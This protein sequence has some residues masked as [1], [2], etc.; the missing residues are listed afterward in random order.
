MR[1]TF[2]LADQF[3]DQ[4]VAE[5]PTLA[6][7]L[8]IAGHDHRWDDLS[9][10]GADRFADLIRGHS[11]ALAPY[12][13]HPDRW[14]RHAARV[15]S[16][17]IGELL[18]AYDRQEHLRALRHLAGDFQDIRDVFDQ[19]GT[20]TREDWDNVIARLTTVSEPLQGHRE[21]LE[22]G[23]H[24]GLAAARRQV[25]AVLEQA[26][27]LAGPEG[28]W[29]GLVEKAQ[30]STDP[31][32]ATRLHEAVTQAQAAVATFGDYLERDYL[33]AAPEA[34][35]VGAERYV[36]EADRYLGLRI[37]PLDTYEWGWEEVERINQA[38]IGT[39]RHI[40]PDA[41][42]EE[43]IERLETD[44]SYA[45]P[46]QEAFIEFMQQ[47]QDQAL[48][49]LDGSHFD[50]PIAIRK[51]TVNLVPPGS[52][53]GAYYLPPSEDFTRPGG[54]WYSFGARPQIPLWGEVS[55]GY[56]EG[57][58]GHHLQV[59]S[60]MANT[61][62]LSRVHRLLVWYAGYG[63]GW[64]LYTERLMDE[65]GYF[66][67]PEYLLGMLA[68]QQLRACR[69]VI[70]IGSHLGYRIPESAPVGGGAAWDFD[71]AVETL[72]RVAGQPLD[73]SK[74]EVTRYLG[75]P[76]QAI[77][78]KVGERAILDLREQAR[79]AGGSDFELK[80]FHHQ[81]LRFGEVRLDYLPELTAST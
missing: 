1:E 67:R 78:Y 12:L 59:G 76:G 63:E 47:L 30:Q 3:V 35:G 70:D 52:A 81:L 45:A 15:A 5:R 4:L 10:Q 57:F 43:V 13:Q 46:S 72:H 25:L 75:W 32:E 66:E 64:A 69:V 16:D 73:V 9:P 38:M 31:E 29:L 24:R 41:T 58:P 22:L 14:E 77:A 6:T 28:K 26:R 49:Q 60:V 53:L 39:A 51:V 44:P 27:H 61:D 74:S 8:G 21:A 18:D 33:P 17:Y 11:A 42:L 62:N 71:N 2:A 80:A 68:A 50:V 79:R 7:M 19:M 37:D 20:E 40:D 36:A 65:L 56:H 55:T 23:R 54:I 48:S 34:D